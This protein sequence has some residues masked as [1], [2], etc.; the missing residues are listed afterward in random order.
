MKHT[1]DIN[2]KTISL[3][4]ILYITDIIALKNGGVNFSIVY[5]KPFNSQTG[6]FDDSESEIEFRYKDEVLAKEERKKLVEFWE[7][8]LS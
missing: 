1:Y 4:N 5:K 7:L 2:G 3:K 6:M 8:Y